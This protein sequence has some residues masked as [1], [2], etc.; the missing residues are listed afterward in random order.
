VTPNKPNREP[1][2]S[3]MDGF[4]CFWWEE[5]VQSNNGSAFFKFRP[6]CWKYFG[7]YGWC[8]YTDLTWW[9]ECKIQVESSYAAWLLEKELSK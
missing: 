4:I 1:D 8:P 6:E 2:L 5:K 3:L 7:V 9:K